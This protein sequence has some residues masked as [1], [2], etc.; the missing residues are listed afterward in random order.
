MARS[1]V[2]LLGPRRTLPEG[3]TAGDCASAITTAFPDVDVETVTSPAA[4]LAALDGGVACLVSSLPLDDEGLAF[5][6]DVRDRNQNVPIVYLANAPNERVPVDALSL[7]V[8][9]HRCLRTA[10]DPAD[11]LAAAVRSVLP[12]AEPD[13]PPAATSE[14]RQTEDAAGDDAGRYRQLVRHIADPVY[15]IDDA[16]YVTMVNEALLTKGGFEREEFVGTHVSEVMPPDDVEQGTE[17]ILELVQSEVTESETFEMEI[18]HADGT[19]REYEDHVSV[20]YDEAGAYE[21][22]VGIVRDIEERKERERELEQYETIVETVPDGV[23]VLDEAG[24]I[25]GGNERAA[26]MVGIEKGAAVGTS[27]SDLVE[28]GIL[29]ATILETYSEI[30]SDLV[31]DASD[32]ETDRFEFTVRPNGSDEERIFEARIALRPYDDAFRGTVGV[33]QDV[34]DRKQRIEEL[35]RYETIVQAIPDTLWAADEDGYFTFINEAGAEQFGYTQAEIE[36]NEIH[37]SEIVSDDEVQKFSE[38]LVRLLSD[39][40]D[41]GEN[42]VVQYT[43]IRKDGRRFPAETYLSPMEPT[44]AG[45]A[46][47]GIARDIT[48]RK[49]REERI[50]VLDRVLRHNLRNDLNAI[51]ANAELLSDRLRT[52]HDD[53]AGARIA[54]VATSQTEQ[55]VETSSDVRQIQ[56][57]LERDRMDHPEIDAVDLV[58]DVLASFQSANP[59]VTIETDLPDRAVVEADES[60]E[61]VVENV[62]ENAIEHHDSDHPKIEVTIAEQDRERGEWFEITV[63]DDGPGIPSQELVAVDDDRTV[64]PL[65]HGS[66]IGLWAV[67]W[68]VQSFGGSVDVAADGAGSVVTLS[69]RKAR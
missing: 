34:T 7:G 39:E 60:L 64:T 57:A 48:E 35:E 5:L 43:G 2:L 47:A 18:I 20:M 50:E 31:S 45:V 41:T 49:Q 17:I 33:V 28:Q 30:V 56:R 25:V 40:Y 67:A 12:E 55:L 24:R 69:L 46:S 14:S 13:D 15:M 65:Q 51:L 66:G 37:F 61:L 1:R 53:E 36:A 26:E 19:R 8:T 52:R 42:A 44:A 11:E 38:A 3:L 62:V 68:I 54:E 58:S 21:G 16:G 23:F 10:D 27:V 32:R 59:G 63:R 6:R 9:E 22:S 29:R 4:A